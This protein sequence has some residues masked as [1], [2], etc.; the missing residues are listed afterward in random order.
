MTRFRLVVGAAI[1]PLILLGLTALAGAARAV[2]KQDLVVVTSYPPS[3]F[4]PYRAAFER[5]HPDI[6]VSIVQRNTASAS[7]FVIEKTDVPADVFWAS[8]TDAFELLKRNGSLRP[9][10]PRNTGAPERVFGYPVNDPG[11][12]YLGFAL[13]G[14]GFVYNPPHLAQNG[15]PVPRA[16][17]D[18]LNPVYSGQ[19]GITTPSRSG[20]THL[21]V[22]ALL[23]TYGWEEGWAMLSQLGGNLSTVTARSFGVASGVAQRRFSIGITIDFLASSPDFAGAGNVFVLPP[24]TV[25]VPAS[26]AILSRARNVPAAE[27]FVDFV[28]SE[29]GQKLLLSPTI[30]RIPV[31]PTLSSGL[32]PPE[33]GARLLKSGGFDAALSARRYGLVNLMFDDYIVRRRATLARLWKRTADLKAMEIKDAQ[34]LSMLARAQGLLATPPLST[35]EVE[36][37]ASSLQGEWPRGVAR[38]PA[39]TDLANKLRARIEQNLAEAEG[40]LSAAARPGGNVNFRPWRQ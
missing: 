39:H 1:L 33:D 34:R 32:L 22:E 30:A 31:N 35:R 17:Q 20:T 6:R 28:L 13:S 9:I 26:I 2:E 11:G 16:W 7:R 25:F 24:D 15:L 21:I 29:P 37:V 3:F 36:N 27:R 4:E 8:A 38:S 23:Q 40:L 12:Y 19:I 18:L 10:A 14:Y 5:G